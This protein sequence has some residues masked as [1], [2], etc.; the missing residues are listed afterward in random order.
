MA[1]AQLGLLAHAAQ[2]QRQG[3]APVGQR[4][5]HLLGL[6]TGHHHRLPRLQLRRLLQHVRQQGLAPQALQHL[7]PAAFHPRALAGSEHHHVER[8]I[9][10]QTPLLFAA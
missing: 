2:Q 7:G 10:P 6:V 5:F 8:K 3:G 4:R 1:G 9:H